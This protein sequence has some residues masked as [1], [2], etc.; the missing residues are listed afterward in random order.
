MFDRYGDA[1]MAGEPFA[2]FLAGARTWL[3]PYAAFLWLRTV[4][5]TGEHW[6]WGAL[7]KPSQEVRAGRGTA[8]CLPC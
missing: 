5:G 7:A 8:A 2:A 6:R 3:Q 1:D 4:M